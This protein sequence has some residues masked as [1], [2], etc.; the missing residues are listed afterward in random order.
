MKQKRI[1]VVSYSQTGQLSRL[2]DSVVGP[3]RDARDCEV[4]H[5]RIAPQVPYPF[6]WP[7]LRFL[8]VFPEKMHAVKI[9]PPAVVQSPPPP[10]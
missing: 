9:G 4:V 5:E 7:F 2:V 10:Q 3:L 1:L 6:P 8:D